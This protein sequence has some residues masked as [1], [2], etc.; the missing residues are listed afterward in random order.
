MENKENDPENPEFDNEIEK[1]KLQAEFGAK[2]FIPDGSDIPPEIE[3]EWLKNVRE[4]EK[5]YQEHPPVSKKIREIL[6]NIKMIPVSE[7]DPALIEAELAKIFGLLEEKNIV[8][9]H[10]DD[11]PVEEL[12]RFVAEELMDKEI[13]LIDLPGGF[14]THLIYEEY[15]PNHEKD[16]MRSIDKFSHTLFEKKAENMPYELDNEL[17]FSSGEIMT[18]KEFIEKATAWFDSIGSITVNRMGFMKPE[19]N[20]E[21]QMGHVHFF[22]DYDVMNLDG[23]FQNYSGPGIFYVHFMF[24]GWFVCGMSYPGFS[25]WSGVGE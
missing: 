18:S 24:G 25:E 2:F 13:E 22:V 1:L 3:A 16:I 7:I 5:A 20:L 17:V 14:A 23:T 12:Y 4:F 9:D 11:V 10:E 19:F 21:Q 8:L 15:H 6:E